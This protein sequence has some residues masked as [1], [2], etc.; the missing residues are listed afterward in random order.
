MADKEIDQKGRGWLG[1]KLAQ[2]GGK[3]DRVGIAKTA[4]YQDGFGGQP[5]S[6]SILFGLM[7]G[8]AGLLGGLASDGF[9]SDYTQPTDGGM[10][11]ADTGTGFE[12]IRYAADRPAVTLVRGEDGGLQLYTQQSDGRLILLSERQA[13]AVAAEIT[14]VL[15]QRIA[16]LNQ[17]DMQV[18][19]NSFLPYFPVYDNLSTAWTYDNGYF[20]HAGTG[21]GREVEIAFSDL[22]EKYAR[23]LQEWIAVRQAITEGRAAAKPPANEIDPGAETASKQQLIEGVAGGAGLVLLGGLFLV[24]AGASRGYKSRKRRALERG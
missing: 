1:L 10:H 12:T 2:N 13:W 3:I 18:G 8:M 11:Y 22:D 14:T 24:G 6:H 9:R 4:V 20:R 15:Q 23:E 16:Q 19:D 5:I 21:N 17:S 7:A